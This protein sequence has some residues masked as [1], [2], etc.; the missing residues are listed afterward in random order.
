[1]QYILDIHWQEKL[2]LRKNRGKDHSVF[3]GFAPVESPKIAI[4]VYVETVVLVLF[5]VFLL[6]L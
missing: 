3:M 6:V 4:A 2:E 1:M 5:M